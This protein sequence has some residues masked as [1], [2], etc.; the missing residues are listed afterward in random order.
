MFAEAA[1]PPCIQS[2]GT[3]VAAGFTFNGGNTDFALA[4]YNGDGSLDTTFSADGK[5][6]TA[7]GA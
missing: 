4:R 5:Q 6:T 3:I 2:D 1:P 7:F